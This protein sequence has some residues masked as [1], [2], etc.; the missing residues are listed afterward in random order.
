MN[1][2]TFNVLFVCTGNSCRSP[3][4]EGLLKT[5]IPDELKD[6]VVVRSAGTLGLVGNPATEEAIQA[7]AEKGADISQHRSRAVNEDLAK[8]S[9]IIFTM[10]VEHKTF[11]E[12]RL[13]EVRENVFL[14]KSF[15]RNSG[16]KIDPNI[17]DP[18]GAGLA[19]YRKCCEEIDAELERILP[20]LTALIKAK[21]DAGE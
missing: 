18:I 12:K 2:D 11:F 17:E 19:V 14:L 6:R 8:S 21:L 10:A 13:P 9:D 16:E 1:L 3:M 4:A 20:R 7:A 15:E 5:K